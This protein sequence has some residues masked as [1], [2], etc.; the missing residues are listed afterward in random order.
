MVAACLAGGCGDDSGKTAD[1]AIPDAP[2]SCPPQTAPYATGTYTYYLNFEGQAI[3]PGDDNSAANTTPLVQNAVTVPR[4]YDTI[5]GD[6]AAAIA[7]IVHLVELKLAPYSI[8]VVTTR[9]A[10]GDYWMSVLGGSSQMIIGSANVGSVAPGRCENNDANSVSLI[11]DS[12]IQGDD[13]YSYSILSDFGALVGLPVTTQ[14]GDCMCRVAGC[15]LNG[16]VTCSFG[17]DVPVDPQTPCGVTTKDEVMHL[18]LAL[19][20]R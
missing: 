5:I 14:N 2:W 10:S 17:T 11:F 12:G 6:R 16:A 13:F 18:A 1:A 3:A 19:G 8:N 9:P 4:F 7:S 20:C 15:S